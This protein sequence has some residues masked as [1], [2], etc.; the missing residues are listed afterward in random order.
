MA[1]NKDYVRPAID[2]VSWDMNQQRSTLSQEDQKGE[3]EAA[4]VIDITTDLAKEKT[5]VVKTKSSRLKE[6]SSQ[7]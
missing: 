4:D 2:L 3:A 5:T 7:C 1:I 6:P